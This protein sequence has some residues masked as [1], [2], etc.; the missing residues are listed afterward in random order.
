V[1]IGD[2]ANLDAFDRLRVSNPTAIFES[3]LVYDKQPLLWDEQLTGAA[4]SVHVPNEAAVKMSVLVEGDK[5]LRQTRQYHR[6]QPGKS[7]LVLLT[8]VLGAPDPNVRRRAGYFDGDNGIFLE[9]IDGDVWLVLRSKATGSVVDTRIAQ[10]DWNLDTFSELAIDKTQILVIDL[11]WLGVGRVRVGFVI[12]GVI[13]Y[14]HEFL[15]ANVRPTVYMSTG[16]LPIRTEIEATGAISADEEFDAHAICA[17]VMSEG[18]ADEA[19][20]FPFSVNSGD[21]R[22]A[23]VADPLLSIRPKA[24]FA[25]LTNRITTLLRGIR[26]V[27][28]GSGLALVEVWVNTTLTAASWASAH[29]DSGIE[30]DE[31]ATSFTGGV[32][33]LSFYV[34]ASVQSKDDAVAGIAGR[35]PITLDIDG[36]NP[37]T[38]TISVTDFGTSVCAAAINWQEYR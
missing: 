34:P 2:G 13:T 15:N 11:Q 1:A 27:N 30:F 29:A 33:V 24:T 3:M 21:A 20:G 18:G 6:Y 9:E 31:V 28:T 22:A 36:L 37:T 19:T 12:D 38:V 17:A 7:Q 10:A 25:G 26:V 16:Q 23:G 35:F 4:T 32:K 5:V 8:G 14:A